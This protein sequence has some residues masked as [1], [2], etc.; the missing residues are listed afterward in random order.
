[1]KTYKELLAVAKPFIQAS[2]QI[3]QDP[4][5]LCK[6][7]GIVY[8]CK[9]QYEEDFNGV[10]PL[11]NFPAI[12]CKKG[13][14]QYI[15]Y[16]DE[17]SKYWRFYFFHEIAHFL[18]KHDFDSLENEQEANMLACIL[19]APMSKLPASLKSVQDLM[20]LAGLPIGR[21]EEYWQALIE[22]GYGTE[23]LMSH[24]VK[25]L[26][27]MSLYELCVELTK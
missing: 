20:Y 22:N 1:M 3:P 2:S 18:L 9:M 25:E 13:N 8:K 7:L 27:N 17:S 16:I 19:I 26:L 24:S 15:I 14:G 4:L 12:L 21:A 10:N 6:K 23:K 5:S 11:V